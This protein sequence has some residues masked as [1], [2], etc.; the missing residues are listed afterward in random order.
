MDELVMVT[1]ILQGFLLGLSYVAPIGMQNLYVIN[2]AL[3]MD[4]SRAYQVALI[5]IFFDITL[6]LACFFGIGI[7]LEKLP[8]LKGVLLLAGSLAI[9][10]IGIK[11]I[12]A[13]P[14]MN[15]EINVNEP[16]IK[17][18]AMCFSVTWFNPQAIIDGTLLL[19]GFRASLPD[20]ASNFFIAGVVMAS[21]TWFT[22]L[23][24]VVTMFKGRTGAN[25]IRPINMACGLVIILYGL[26]LGYS[27]IQAYL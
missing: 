21:A 20:A 25:A 2:T 10:Y 22:G 17:I 8:V 1:Y 12:L 4:R 16:F 11:L 7:L 26:K 5:T 6:A 27:F 9:L 23:A 13:R 15:N 19:G 14:S 3:K 18:V 24:T